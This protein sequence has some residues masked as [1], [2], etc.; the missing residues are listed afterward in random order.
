MSQEETTRT[1]L[2]NQRKVAS[3]FLNNYP[4]PGLTAMRFTRE[5]ARPGLGVP[6]NVNVVVSVAGMDYNEI[7]AT[8]DVWG[9]DPLPELR[10]GSTRGPV[11]V[12]YSDGTTEVFQ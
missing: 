8:N 12:T 3:Q 7:L 10:P 6:W 5:G 1:N 9:G 2:A 11:S 4:H